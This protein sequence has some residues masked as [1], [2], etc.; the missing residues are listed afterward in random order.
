MIKFDIDIYITIK[1]NLIKYNVIIFLLGG[2]NMEDP[3]NVFV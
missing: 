2:L 1:Y 3:Q